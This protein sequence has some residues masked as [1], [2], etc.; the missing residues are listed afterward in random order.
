MTKAAARAALKR[1]EAF[2]GEWTLEASF[3]GSPPGR[4]AF[5]WALGGQ[6]LVQRTGAPDPAP[7]SLAIISVDPDRG[8]YTQHYFDT[9]GVVRL[10]AM[11]L[12][13]GAWQLLRT[14]PDFTPL[15]FSQR[16]R[17]RFSRDRRMIKGAWETS[18]DGKRWKHD[19]DL[20]YR[21]VKPL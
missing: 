4:V 10:Y 12:S 13:N 14:K 16:F 15:D 8:T 20:I 1:L 7:D 17:G 5:E 6:L 19:F 21:K 2:I 11:T 3:P 9:R 18:G